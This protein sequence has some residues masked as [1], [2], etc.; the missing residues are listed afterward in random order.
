MLRRGL[1]ASFS[2][3]EVF[4]ST[5]GGVKLDPLVLV[6]SRAHTLTAESTSLFQR[7]LFLGL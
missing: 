3:T 6:R 2:I 1:Q 7:A 5:R 4:T